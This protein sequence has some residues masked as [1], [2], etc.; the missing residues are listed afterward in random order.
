MN[1]STGP[2]A[3]AGSKKTSDEDGDREFTD[4]HELTLATEESRIESDDHHYELTSAAEEC[5]M[6]ENGCTYVY[7]H[8]VTLA[9]DYEEFRNND[10]DDHELTIATEESRIEDD[11]ELTSATEVMTNEGDGSF[12]DENSVA[13]LEMDCSRRDSD[14]NT[15]DSE[16]GDTESHLNREDIGSHSNRE[17]SDNWEGLHK[18][19]DDLLYPGS[20]ITVKIVMISLCYQ[21]QANQ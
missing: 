9:V 10:D 13:D 4:G 17:D 2:V 7:G 18:H 20:S 15:S 21:T 14:I 19:D 1:L 5:R 12:N 8:K 3:V 11:H 16:F 6:N